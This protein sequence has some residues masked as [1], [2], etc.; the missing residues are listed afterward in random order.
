MKKLIVVLLSAAALVS[1]ASGDAKVEKDV[2]A[3]L[4]SWKQA[5]I[6]KD[7][8]LFEKIYHPDLTY[9]H[10]SGL[11]ENKEQAIKHI[12]ESKGAYTA[13]DFGDMTVRVYGS[14]ALVT[15]K[16][17]LL[18][19]AADG[20]ATTV[21]LVTLHGFVKTPQGWQMVARQAARLPQ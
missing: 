8:A 17:N 1:A 11:V 3:A 9:G 19:T 6:K 12:V 2:M 15:G 20:K 16:V 13:V 21:K 10:S 18:E 7:R 5:C 4:D 14:T